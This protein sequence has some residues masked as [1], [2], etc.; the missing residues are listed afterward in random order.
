MGRHK[1]AGEI[2]KRRMH[3]ILTI[4]PSLGERFWQRETWTRYRDHQRGSH[5]TMI[6]HFDPFHINLLIND[7]NTPDPCAGVHR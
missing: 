6:V 2:R 5:G 7:A 3:N 4:L 1:S